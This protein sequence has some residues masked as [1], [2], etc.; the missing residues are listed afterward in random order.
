M[1]LIV[2]AE[3]SLDSDAI[4]EPEAAIEE[5]VAVLVG[6]CEKA[7]FVVGTYQ[8][9]IMDYNGNIVGNITVEVK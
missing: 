2:K 1:K 3:V 6:R 8:E 9:S 5:I 4:Q 7:G